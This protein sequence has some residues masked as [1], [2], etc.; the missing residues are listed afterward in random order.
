MT[1]YRTNN[2]V[3]SKLFINWEKHGRNVMLGGNPEKAIKKGS[4][5]GKLG[6]LASRNLCCAKRLK[7]E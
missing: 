1:V 6:G 5:Q 2:A 3:K 4:L 7:P